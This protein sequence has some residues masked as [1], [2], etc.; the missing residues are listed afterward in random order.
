MKKILLALLV[1]CLVAAGLVIAFVPNWAGDGSDAIGEAAVGDTINFGGYTWQVLDVQGNRA[2]LITEH[3]IAMRPFY[4]RTGEITWAQSDIRAWLNDSFLNSFS[5]RERSRIVQTTVRNDA[6]PVFGTTGGDDTQDYVF[7]LSI[8]EVERY[9]DDCDDARSAVI[10]SIAVWEQWVVDF[11]RDRG[12]RH[13]FMLGFDT[14]PMPQSWGLRSPGGHSTHA[15]YIVDNGEINRYG[16]GIGLG[17][18]G[19]RP[20]IW[21]DLG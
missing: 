7:L 3:I 1:L 6:N 16:H 11:G 15:A 4:P 13:A 5:A 2:L 12:V 10:P 21:V 9:F 19:I 17:F 18:G 20:V 14:F 8:E